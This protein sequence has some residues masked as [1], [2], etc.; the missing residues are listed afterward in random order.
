[1]NNYREHAIREFEF[2]GWTENGKFKDSMQ[3][4]ICTQV[5]ELL[6]LFAEHGHSGSSHSY[7]LDLFSD[8]AKF[9][10]I[11]PLSGADIEWSKTID[12][13]GTV[14]NK[15]LSSVFKR[16]D[17]TAYYLDAIIW[18]SEKGGTWC[19]NAGDIS[20]RQNISFPFTPKTFYIDVKE[21]NEGNFII[22]D[23]IQLE[24]VKEYYN[25]GDTGC[26]E[27]PYRTTGQI[28]VDE[29]GEIMNIYVKGVLVNFKVRIVY[30]RDVSTQ[31][32]TNDLGYNYKIGDLYF[33]DFIAST[34]DK[35]F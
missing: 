1:M 6:D 8:L 20:S 19:G 24:A 4:L 21:D 16:K 13:E 28:E 27:Q 2:V 15:R 12:D 31:K 29:N 25:L 33:A 32:E 17:G 18:K 23:K 11:S 34:E 35:L 7:A 14:Q 10:P 9:K 30:D 22:K 5:L 26:D 3:E